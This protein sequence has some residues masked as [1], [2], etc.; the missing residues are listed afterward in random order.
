MEAWP[1]VDDLI[2]PHRIIPGLQAIRRHRGCG[3]P[4]ALDEFADRYRRLRETRPDD[5]SVGGDAYR[6]GFYS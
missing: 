3:I 5:F 4:E 6:E 1:E 2:V